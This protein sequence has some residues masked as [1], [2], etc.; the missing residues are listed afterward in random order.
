MDTSVS[1]GMYDSNLLEGGRGGVGWGGRFCTHRC[2]PA[3][4]HHFACKFPQRLDGEGRWWRGGGAKGACA[5]CR[6][7]TEGEKRREKR[8]EKEVR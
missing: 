2:M 1:M 3:P 5:G 7:R 6:K 8:V 4:F